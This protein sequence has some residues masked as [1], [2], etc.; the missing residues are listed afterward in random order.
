MG[1]IDSKLDLLISKIGLKGN[2]QIMDYRKI[3]LN[4]IFT[5]THCIMYKSRAG[6]IKAHLYAALVLNSLLF[7]IEFHAT[8]TIDL[9]T[10][11]LLYVFF[12]RK[13]ERG[14]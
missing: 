10:L 5:E 14:T 6:L 8:L 7:G 12:I 11:S 2:I 9:A 13:I 1:L 3:T 4:Q